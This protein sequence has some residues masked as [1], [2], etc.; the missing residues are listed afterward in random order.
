MRFLRIILS[1][2]A[3]LAAV[4]AGGWS[5]YVVY[6][7]SQKDAGIGDAF[8]ISIKLP[9]EAPGVE[10]VPLWSLPA[11]AVVL[12][13]VAIVL[14]PPKGTKKGKKKEDTSQA[15]AKKAL[16]MQAQ[17]SSGPAPA[18]EAAV[19]PAVAA[20]AEAQI[21]ADAAD[22]STYAR[23]EDPEAMARLVAI[24]QGEMSHEVVSNLI[25]EYFPELASLAGKVRP[26]D[27]RT[28]DTLGRHIIG[29]ARNMLKM[30]DKE[31][32]D[33]QFAIFQERNFKAEAEEILR[34]YQPD[35]V[36]LLS[37]EQRGFVGTVV[38]NRSWET[39]QRTVRGQRTDWKAISLS[40][41]KEYL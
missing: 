35:D 10:T 32:S 11:A 38:D 8:K 23:L 26:D 17:K 39:V 3:L 18:A 24:D 21:E 36:T 6:V 16:K 27:N 13:V 20:E 14:W 34:M 19:D 40:N 2:P 33:N 41:A 29:I 37:D 31:L 15:D 25:K 7:L 1:I 12:L 28:L 9:F 4:A 22:V 5:G 30:T